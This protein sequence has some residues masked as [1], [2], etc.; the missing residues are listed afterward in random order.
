MVRDLDHTRL[1]EQTA[2]R[3][4]KRA[5]PMTNPTPCARHVLSLR[6]T[7]SQPEISAVSTHAFR[8][9]PEE[10]EFAHIIRTMLLGDVR[11][12]DIFADVFD[13]ADVFIDDEADWL[14]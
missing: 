7:A 3:G 1:H 8:F 13:D 4:A 9:G 12:E 11:I 14:C 2:L 6:Y 10:Q 5:P